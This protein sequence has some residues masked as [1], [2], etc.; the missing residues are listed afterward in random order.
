MVDKVQCVGGPKSVSIAKIEMLNP[1]IIFI[2]KEESCKNLI[3]KLDR[4]YYNCF[5][6]DINSFED[7]LRMIKTI[8]LIFNKKKETQKL[9]NKINCKFNKLKKSITQLSFIYMI[10]SK[11]YIAAGNNNY[12]N[13]L[14][15]ELGF[16]N[17]FR[18]EPERY[19]S[20]SA[21]M[22][23]LKSPDIVFL[24]SE[25]YNYN[26]TDKIKFKKIFPGARIILVD[27]EMFCWY[28]S[29]MLPAMDYIKKI[30]NKLKSK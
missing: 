19:I 3:E 28:G 25:P 17:C 2:I 15:N 12:I 24:P 5:I 11:P 27:G 21:G 9:I 6:F 13:S 29:R 30:I 4:L 18:F 14:L 20:V 7:G 26:E 10:W 22:L 16:L 23:K 1:D 8:G